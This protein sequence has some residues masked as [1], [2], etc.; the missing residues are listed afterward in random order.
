MR[1]LVVRAIAVITGLFAGYFAGQAAAAEPPMWV[2]EDSDSKV[3]LYPTIHFLPADLEWRSAALDAELAAADEV[4]FE[5]PQ[6]P[7]AQQ[8]VQAVVAQH[9]IDPNNPLSTVLP[10][11]T[12]ARLTAT[13]ETM[14]IPM[15][16]IETMKPWLATLMIVSV[17]LMR[18]GFDPNAGVEA[19]LAGSI[20]AERQRALE[21]AD[22][23]VRAL[24][25]LPT[26]VQVRFL[27]SALDEIDEGTDRLRDIATDWANGNVESM[28]AEIIDEMKDAYP[29]VY[30]ALFVR[31]NQNWSD[32]IVAELEGA[33]TD[34]IAVGAG[35]L[36]GEDSVPAMLKAR[37]YDVRM[38]APA[39]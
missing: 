1:K 12:Y 28:E 6:T 2:I 26:D 33:G 31:R 23:Q 32:Q 35:H 13:A 22:G 8:T 3:V 19:R 34:F 4:W 15:A 7:D 38:L 29:E 10:E 27:E 21:T 14:G 37:G 5:L 11:A 9:G 25:D 17:E 39:Q 30:E 20:D 18:A 36:V 16:Q 24:A